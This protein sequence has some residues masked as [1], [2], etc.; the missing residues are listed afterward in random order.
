MVPSRDYKFP[1]VSTL[2]SGIKIKPAIGKPLREPTT[3]GCL[4]NTNSGNPIDLFALVTVLLPSI[5]VDVSAY[6]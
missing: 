3:G 5:G 6:S 2:A 1:Y 4:R